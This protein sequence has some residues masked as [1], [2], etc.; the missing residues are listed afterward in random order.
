MRVLKRVCVGVLT[1]GILFSLSACKG[2]E[3][4]TPPEKKE[5]ITTVKTNE[6][7]MQS[8]EGVAVRYF[9]LINAGYYNDAVK[10]LNLKSTDIMSA[11]ILERLY[12]KVENYSLSKDYRVYGVSASKTSFNRL[13]N[14]ETYNVTLEFGN[15]TDTAYKDESSISDVESDE[16]DPAKGLNEPYI[17]PIDFASTYELEDYDSD[18]KLTELD[19]K[20]EDKQLVEEEEYLSGDDDTVSGESVKL[21]RAPISVKELAKKSTSTASNSTPKSKGVTEN[22]SKV[23]KDE[24]KVD[25]SDKSSV[26]SSISNGFNESRNLEGSEEDSDDYMYNKKTNDTYTLFTID[27][28]VQKNTETGVCTVNLPDTFFNNTEVKVIVPKNAKLLFDDAIVNPS[29]VDTDEFYTIPRI[30]QLN[31]WRLTIKTGVDSDFVRDIDLTKRVYYTYQFLET[32]TACRNSVLKGVKTAVQSVYTSI[33]K[34]ESFSKSKFVT[35]YVS[36]KA[37]K[38]GFKSYYETALLDNKGVKEYT[39][40]SVKLL[41]DTYIPSQ[42]CIPDSNYIEIKVQVEY[43]YKM[44][45]DGNKSDYQVSRGTREGTIQMSKEKGVW[46]VWGIDEELI[47][48]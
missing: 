9:Y 35:K 33:E 11:T 21:T 44:Y 22:S 41:D 27:I 24:S 39:V 12:N 19:M 16:I 40:I 7:A 17:S 34:K 45:L 13:E 48:G 2:G 15:V 30:P 43:S 8:V 23:S 18:G 20:E 42:F 29:M 36:S 1:L 25:K 46:K 10:L 6:E 3:P 32:S 37:N 38:N 14:T 4:P 47:S 28:S 26:E 31:D 5:T